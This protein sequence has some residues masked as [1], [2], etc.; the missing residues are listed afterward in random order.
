MAD[1]DHSQE[2]EHATGVRSSPESQSNEDISLTE[3]KAFLGN[4]GYAQR[5]HAHL[6]ENARFAGFNPWA[7]VLGM[8]WFAYRRLYLHGL[9]ALA[10]QIVIPAVLGAVPFF[11]AGPAAHTLS[12][13]VTF[14]A[15]ISV[16]VGLGF[17]ANV[18]L[19]KRVVQTIQEVDAL[20]LDND[21]HVQMIAA[22]GRVSVG[23]FFIA[24]GVVGVIDR[25][26]TL[27]F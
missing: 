13:T 21:A 4:D 14:A 11:L 12:R 9:A 18:A 26:L 24:T 1:V 3:F 7:A 6:Q 16:R 5:L 22:C 8:G 27:G 23:A 17:W 19:S 2:H 10:L 20:N 25:F 15:L